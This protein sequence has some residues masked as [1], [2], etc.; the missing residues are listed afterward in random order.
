MEVALRREIREET[1]LEIEGIQFIGIKE[2]M[3]SATFYE[4]KH[5][6]F[7]DYLCKTTM[8]EVTL[9]DEAEEYIWIDIEEMDKYALGGF[10]K[11]L[12]M[13]IKNQD[14]NKRTEVFYNY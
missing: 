5:F 10:T 11:E 4:K 6:I 13:N 7:L 2:S 1:G 14:K 3:Y 8:N 9:N 12:L